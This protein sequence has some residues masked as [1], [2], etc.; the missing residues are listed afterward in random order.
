MKIFLF[1]ILIILTTSCNNQTKHAVYDMLHERERQEC[2][3]QGRS[4]C[5]GAESYDQ[6]KQKRDETINPQEKLYR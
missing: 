5:P 1:S 2:L 3:K 4:D 6:Y